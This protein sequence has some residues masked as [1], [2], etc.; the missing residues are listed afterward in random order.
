MKYP[1]VFLTGM[2][3][4]ALLM[5]LSGCAGTSLSW[6]TTQPAA[7]AVASSGTP[8]PRVQ[9]CIAINTGTP[10]KYVCGGKTYTSHELRKM[11][12]E[13]AAKAAS[14]TS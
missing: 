9:D 7:P 8:V 10:S 1:P 12:E 3:A 4:C 11:R 14:A 13:Q 6:P 5:A 2:A